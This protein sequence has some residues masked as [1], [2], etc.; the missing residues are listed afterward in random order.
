MVNNS[1]IFK[2]A[3]LSNFYRHPM[4]VIVRL[5]I[6]G[7]LIFLL[8]NSV[9]AGLS[10][11]GVLFLFSVFLIIETF[12]HF[13]IGKIRPVFSVSDENVDI[14][15]TF[16]LP[17][18]RAFFSQNKTSQII[19]MLLKYPQINFILHKSNIARTELPMLEISK[20]E[21][22]SYA[23]NL[24]KNIN[25][26]YVTTM[27]IFAAYIFLI[28]PQ[29][30]LL[31]TKEL[32]QAEFLHIL[33]WARFDF[34]FEE[35]PK[36]V[37]IDSWGAGFAEGWVAG[38]TIETKKY[39]RD[40][41]ERV[42]KEKPVLIG[43]KEEYKRLLE[44]LDRQ[45]KN[46]VLLVGEPG[47]GKTTLIEA[48]CFASFVGRL[49][50]S[51]YHQRVLELLVG[52]M[53]AGTQNQ[54][55]LE[56]R[57]QAIIEEISHGGNVIIYIPEFQDVLGASTFNL[58]LSGAL[59]PYIKD[60]KFRFIAT[61]TLGN[62]KRHIEPVNTF[63]DIFE[64]I[65]IEE[66]DRETA[67]KMLLEKATQIEKKY[68]VYLTYQS[69]SAAVD[70]AKR[71]IQDRTLPGAAV[72]L[73][74]DTSAYVKS[75]KREE[76]TKEDVFSKIEEKTKVNVALP[77]DE[78]K[79]TLLHLEEKLHER[80]IDQE[81]A[82]SAIAESLRRLRSGIASK[83]KP[84]SFLFLGPTGVGKTETAKALSALY[85]KG[86]DKMI[87]LDMS[88]YAND[89]G[90]KRLLGASA[91]EG[92]ERGELTDKIY[93]N[94]F[95]LVLL[96]EF[97]KAHPKILDLFLQVLDDGRLTDNKGK[98]V[99]FANSIIIATSNGASEF[100]REEIKKGQMVDKQFKEKLLEFLQTKGIF[101]PELLN[102]F[103]NLVV[104]KPLSENE[105]VEIAKLV[106]KELSKKL[107]EKDI[108]VNFDEKI[109]A[110]IVKEGSDEQFGARPIKRFVQDNI[111]DLLAQ[112]M[113]RDEI[114]RG[115]T[116]VL[117]TD[118]TGNLTLSAA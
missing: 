29:T 34:P 80:V 76:V 2:F 21:L 66:P 7:L 79:E 99:S 38:W 117:S 93:E 36:P 67:I 16:T 77:T 15:Q 56:A 94:P 97:E 110:K 13:K 64:V 59:L 106:L 30:K 65:K 52:A 69:V 104:F 81:E 4:M 50:G 33:C 109:I 86:E 5:T 98:T 8:T 115:D 22:S 72:T 73:L 24:V 91:G 6:F 60:E 43:R 57:L 39:T 32:K 113:L 85:F 23:F 62:F 63:T 95:S 18:A 116:V 78:E 44:V 9:N 28:E 51:L 96:D 88:E 1:L 71:Y 14:Y 41:T 114:K 46:N 27:D 31:F 3:R 19:K 108:S 35:N 40:I 70:L 89:D 42:L 47:V 53:L 82:I 49:T 12:F 10:V 61:S 37:R 74:N 55:D 118:T 84:I 92:N 48:F 54:G 107:A 100:I 45:E 101:K 75:L 20:E 111:E 68:Q 25:G 26:R 17:A 103:D 112:K 105:V 83:I 58:N 102:R 11:K 90:I 87:R